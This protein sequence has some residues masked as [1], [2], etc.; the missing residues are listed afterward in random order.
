MKQQTVLQQFLGET[1]CA[2]LVAPDVGC[3]EEPGGA[4]RLGLNGPQQAMGDA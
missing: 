2:H 3:R 4:G 1:A